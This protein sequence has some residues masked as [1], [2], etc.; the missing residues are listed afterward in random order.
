MINGETSE[1]LSIRCGEK[2]VVFFSKDRVFYVSV[3]LG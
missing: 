1:T 2:M 3:N